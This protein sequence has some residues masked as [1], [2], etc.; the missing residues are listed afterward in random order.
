M[1]DPPAGSPRLKDCDI[2]MKGGITSGVVY[3]TSVFELSRAYRFRSIG[4][5]S[6]G[7]IAAAATA[8]AELGRCHGDTGG[9]ERLRGLPA[10]LQHSLLSL[11]QPAPPGRPAFRLLLA[12]VGRAPWWRKAI[13]VAVA[14]LRSHPAALVLGGA[15]GF[16]LAEALVAVLNAEPAPLARNALRGLATLGGAASLLAGDLLWRTRRA[17]LANGF[18]LCSGLA[19]AEDGPPALGEWLHRLLNTL[20]GKDADGPPLT[21]G[22]LWLGRRDARPPG[23]EP[24]PLRDRV[25]NLEVMTCNLTHARPHRLPFETRLFHFRPRDL[26][27]CLPGPV[28]DWMTARSSPGRGQDGSDDGFRRLP[29]PADLPV[30]FAVR[31]S[32]SFPLLLSAVPLHA[33]DWGRPDNRAGREEGRLE[34]EPCW[35]SDGGIGSNFPIHFFDA[36]LPTRPTFGINL[37]PFPYGGR[38][39]E[40]DE[41]ANVHFPVDLGSGVIP[42]WNRFRGIPGF[43]AAIVKTMQNWVDSTQLKLPGYRDRVVHVS[44]AGDEG[45]MNLRMEPAVVRRLAE[46]GACAGRELVERFDWDRHRWTRYRTALS[47][48][49]ALLDQVG[50]AWGG[51]LPPGTPT[52]REFVAGRSP[53]D[54][55][56]P[57]SRGEAAL[58]ATRALAELG[59]AW[60]EAGVDFGAEAPRPDPELLIRP[61]L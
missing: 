49:Q 21:F 39:D 51:P 61:R 44:L 6:A 59:R 50:R 40:G 60:R 52:F 31:L 10:E 34:F 57:L 27:R 4:G 29:D 53:G 30:V 24:P 41:R 35:F 11:F 26:R 19:Q 23:G 8:A 42:D 15:L 28:V 46:R 55:P 56:Y 12:L 48:I 54:R 58:E 1:S 20:A 7:A 13:R 17:L 38:R 25:V 2:V 3:P 36:L 14:V 18:G 43:L 47:E 5:T 9:F 32:L 33:V 16:G 45:G 37:R 22:E